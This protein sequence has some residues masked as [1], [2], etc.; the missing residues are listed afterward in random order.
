MI[1]IKVLADEAM[2]IREQD[3]PKLRV[4]NAKQYSIV[5]DLLG[6]IGKSKFTMVEVEKPIKKQFLADITTGSLYDIDTMRCQT[7]P[8]TLQ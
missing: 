1:S 3:M 4:K 8:L 5:H 2:C 6:T 7:G